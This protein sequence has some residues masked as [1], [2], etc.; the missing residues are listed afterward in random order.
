MWADDPRTTKELFE[1][2]LRGDYDDDAAWDAVHA[3]RLRKTEEVFQLA[4]QFT[5]SR[6]PLER[7]RGLEVLAQLGIHYDASVRI[8]VD[9][10][11]DED[12]SV[13]SSAAWSLAHLGGDVAVTALIAMRN[14]GD[15]DVRWAVANLLSGADR[16]DAIGTLI[17]LMDD[18]NDNVRDWATFALGTQCSVDS[19]EIRDALTKRLSDSYDDARAEAVWGL[20]RRQDKQGIRMLIEALMDSEHGAG[21]EMAAS[22]LDV[23]SDT[24]VEQLCDGLRKLLQ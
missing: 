2:S 23:P 21:H 22:E 6:A 24:P 11:T 3:L 7:A 19:A 1:A 10:L 17:E 15:P 20:A 13:V 9:R 18:V 5:R 14:N 16:S 8:A 4:E 12:P